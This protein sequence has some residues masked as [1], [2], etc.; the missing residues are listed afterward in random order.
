M[1][2]LTNAERIP[3]QLRLGWRRKPIKMQASFVVAILCEPTER[4]AALDI[5][6]ASDGLVS[7]DAEQVAG[8][9]RVD[10]TRFAVDAVVAT[11]ITP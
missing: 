8:T 7:H 11:G 10:V 3:D 5:V 9:I 2:T 1:P 4:K 6:P